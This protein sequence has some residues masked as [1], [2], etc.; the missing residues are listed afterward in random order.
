MTTAWQDLTPREILARVRALLIDLDGVMYRGNTPLRGAPELLPALGS[1]G[2]EHVFVTNNSVLTPDQF[3]Q[4]LADMAV[5]TGA[6]RVVTSAEATAA[7]L[8]TVEPPG[9]QLLV[10]GEYGLRAALTNAGFN[11]TDR[12]P[13]C[14]VVGLDRELTYAKLAQ[15]CVAIRAGAR[16][17]ATNG[18]PALPVEDAWWPGAG[19]IVAALATA[20]A[21]LPTVIGKPGSILLEVALERVHANPTEAA[22]VGD[23]ILTDVAAGRAAGLATILVGS[24]QPTP[25]AEPKPD[26][27]VADLPGLIDQLRAARA[28]TAS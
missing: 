23:Q 9:A 14:V 20:T 25:E 12:A 7:Y 2:I 17:V 26:L 22:M 21:V 15:A 18:D 11:V 19:S 10:V 27:W 13:S 5:K 3:A 1:L 8:R 24:D 4:K 28:S 6:E 16:F